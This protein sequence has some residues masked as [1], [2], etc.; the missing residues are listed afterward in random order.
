MGI[1]PPS[2]PPSSPAL[3]H[4]LFLFALETSERIHGASR[5]YFSVYTIIV[6]GARRW[7][8]VRAG[9]VRSAERGFIFPPPCVHPHPSSLSLSLSLPPL[10]IPSSPS[11]RPERPRGHSFSSFDGL[12][13]LMDRRRQFLTGNLT[14]PLSD[15]SCHCPL[16]FH[17]FSVNVHI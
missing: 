15:S 14:G 11:R 5:A 16:A 9:S 1:L 3:P 6:E 7:Y 4:H 17:P 13:F 2:L 8:R 12:S 10:S